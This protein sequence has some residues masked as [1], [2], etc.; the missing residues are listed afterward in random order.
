MNAPRTHTAARAVEYFTNKLEFSTGPIEVSHRI[1][2]NEDISI[3]D[4][5]AEE[6]FQKGHV[7]GAKNLREMRWTTEEGLR[8]DV[9]NIIYCYTPTCHLAARACQKFAGKGYEVMEMDGGFEAWK[10]NGLILEKATA[11]ENI[12]EVDI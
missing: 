11:E 7:P 3:I 5:R 8:K 2:D 4:V 10:D 12:A 6:D 9:I 1:E